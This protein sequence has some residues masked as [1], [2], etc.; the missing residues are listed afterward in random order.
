VSETRPA[1]S[2][3][4]RAVVDRLPRLQISRGARVLDAPCGD[5]ALTLALRDAGYDAWGT[6]VVPAARARLGEKFLAADLGSGIPCADASIDLVLSVEGIEHLENPHAF[7]RDIH[8]VLRPGGLLVLTT[9]NTLSLRSRLRF[10]GSGFYNQDPR[11]LNES[12]R[13]PLHHI[14]LRTFPELRY[15]LHTAHLALIE[16]GH[17]HI[18]PVSFL[19]SILVP[20]AAIYTAMAFRKEKDAAQQSRNRD[21]RRALLSKSVLYGE[22]LLLVARRD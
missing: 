18:K 4:E 3:I 10:L 14:A 2:V 21:I 22:N 15:A 7:L 19:Y 6:D 13:H 5:G 16:V 9:P 8:R 20:A 11:P 12:A 17:T 1:L